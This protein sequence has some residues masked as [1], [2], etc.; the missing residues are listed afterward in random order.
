MAEK[1]EINSI[2]SAINEI[3][4]R[5]KKKSINEASTKSFIPKLN[6][7]LSIPP[8]VDKLIKT[9]EDYKKSL[10]ISSDVPSIKTQLNPLNQLKNEEPLVLENE[11]I[12]NNKDENHELNQLKNKVKNLQVIEKELHLQISALKKDKVLLSVSKDNDIELKNINDFVRKTKETLKD[13]YIQVQKQKQ[14]FIELNNQSFKL[15]QESDFYKENYERLIIENNEIKIRLKILKEQVLK[16]E[17]DKSD[18]LLA[19]KQLNEILSKSNIVGKI[20]SKKISPEK[21]NPKK[22]TYIKPID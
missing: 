14:L 2:L 22:E 20:S 7:D 10:I 18:L 15:K 6:Q 3:N 21:I 8:D 16:H 1:D 17:T 13:L 19:S 9:A 5:P 4:L 11:F 12:E